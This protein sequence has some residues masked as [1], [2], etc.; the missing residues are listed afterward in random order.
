MIDKYFGGFD[1]FEDMMESFHVDPKALG[2]TD[3]N[4]LLACYD[5]PS[6]EGYAFVLL[7]RGK[8]LYEVHGSHCSCNGLEDQWDEGETSWEALEARVKIGRKGRPSFDMYGISQEAVN[9]LMGLLSENLK[10]KGKA[11]AV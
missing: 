7:K 5:T 10:K 4:I 8:K 2:L 3:K 1:D 11:N 6:Y 9:Y